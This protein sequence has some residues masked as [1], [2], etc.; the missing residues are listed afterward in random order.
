[1][2]KP[3]VSAGARNE[4]QTKFLLDNTVAIDALR[5]PLKMTATLK[6]RALK[7]KAK[8]GEAEISSGRSAVDLMIS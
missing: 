4:L 2:A 7:K 3:T 6:R 5:K 1:M 8:Q